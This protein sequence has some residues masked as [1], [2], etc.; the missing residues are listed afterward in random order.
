MSVAA[1]ALV[2]STGPTTLTVGAVADGQVLSRSGSTI[3]GVAAGG[4]SGGYTRQA[5]S[6]ATALSG[7]SSIYAAITASFDGAITLPA[8]NTAGRLVTI[9]D[10]AGVGSG[11]ANGASENIIYVEVS[12][13]GT[14]AITAPDL[15]TSRTRLMLWKRYG[16][17]TLLDDGAGGWHAL[18]RRGWH[19]DPRSISGLEFWFDSRR[20]ITL[21]G[22]AVSAW[23]DLSGNNVDVVQAT[24]ANQPGYQYPSF[25]QDQMHAGEAELGFGSTLSLNSSATVAFTSGF[26]TLVAMHGRAASAGIDGALFTTN[27]TASLGLTWFPQRATGLGPSAANDSYF[28]GNGTGASSYVVVP[29][30]DVRGTRYWTTAMRTGNGGRNYQRWSR[31]R[32]G[33]ANLTGAIGNFTQTVTIGSGYVGFLHT[34]ML[35]DAD[36]TSSNIFDLESALIET[37]PSE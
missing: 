30:P 37:F 21:N 29:T 13:T 25:A 11:D 1:R 26:A 2:E 10:E 24:G 34:I 33:S 28:R 9:T 17:L 18:A 23:A 19:V 31:T 7:T 16:T 15:A 6:T 8:A 35:F 22:N 20:G 14:E 5:V 36:L 27:V 12:N 32:Q 3:I 4:G